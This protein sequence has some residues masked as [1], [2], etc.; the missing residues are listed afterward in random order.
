MQYIVKSKLP[1]AR[2]ETGQLNLVEEY[3]KYIELYNNA[4]RT[5]SGTATF[6]T[7]KGITYTTE[8]YKDDDDAAEIY[9][10]G[11]EGL[12]NLLYL[13]VLHQYVVDESWINNVE[14][15]VSSAPI[16][17]DVNATYS[18][19]VIT[20]ESSSTLGEMSSLPSKPFDVRFYA[21]ANVVSGD[22]L[23]IMYKNGS[24]TFPIYSLT[25]VNIPSGAWV[26]GA[27]VQLTV[28]TSRGFAMLGGY[29]KS[30]SYVS[31]SGVPSGFTE[32]D[33]K[34][35]WID[36]TTN[37]AYYWNNAAGAWK[38]IAGTFS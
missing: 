21:P 3:L 26:Q 37:I 31:K 7:S 35:L 28:S 6:T 8:T 27:I 14:A 11:E 33:K 5:N 38:P 10:R 29:T 23:K 25:S 24:Q 12:M 9:G 20:I 36:E 1:N 32:E 19:G 2:T 13:K 15:S 30:V 4:D 22:R 16:V 34:G 17:Y 18:G